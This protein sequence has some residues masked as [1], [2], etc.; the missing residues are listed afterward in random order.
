MALRITLTR[1]DGTEVSGTIT[2]RELQTLTR[3][4]LARRVIPHPTPADIALFTD[5]EA[6]AGGAPCPTT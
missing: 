5:I 6:P 4:A 2:R 1:E 3:A